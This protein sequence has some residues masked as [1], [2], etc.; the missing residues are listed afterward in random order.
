MTEKIV[1]AKDFSRSP[2]GRYHP[3]DGDFSGQRFREEFLYPA[4]K[5]GKVEVNL[6][7]C[8]TLGSSFLDEAFGGLVR[9]KGLSVDYLMNN[10]V[11]TGRI[12]TFV[13]KAW[14]H[15]KD[16]KNRKK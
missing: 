13:N 7:G 10:L 11:I 3:A 2:S 14:S 9:E 5:N 4:L 12:A 6:D 8:L 1:I 16:P 15:I